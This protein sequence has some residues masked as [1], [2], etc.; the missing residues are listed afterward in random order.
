[1]VAA[2]ISTA[3]KAGRHNA[4]GLALP[5]AAASKR[6]YDRMVELG[7]GELDRSGVAELTFPGRGPA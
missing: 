5:L 4:A 1:V 6:Q 3:S 7:I 2:Q